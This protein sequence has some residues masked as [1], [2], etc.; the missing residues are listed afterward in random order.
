MPIRPEMKARYP[1]NWK[2]IRID[3]ATR[4]GWKCEWCGVPNR[5]V[6]QR[7]ADGLAFL[8]LTVDPARN[9]KDGWAKPVRIVCTVAHVYDPAPEN[10]DPSNLAF[11]CQ[12]CHNRHDAK[13]RAA[14]RAE[15]A[16]RTEGV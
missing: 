3:I 2:A 5:R 6:I 9:L 13:A 7:S 10:C 1:K 12:R 8:D 16:T 15:R 14:G 11:L 4:A